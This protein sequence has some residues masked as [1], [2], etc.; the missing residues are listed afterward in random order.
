[1]QWKGS[2]ALISLWVVI[3]VLLQVGLLHRKK[4]IQHVI[5]V[6]DRR[7]DHRKKSVQ[8]TNPT[9]ANVGK[10]AVGDSPGC[11][12]CQPKRSRMGSGRW[13]TACKGLVRSALQGAVWFPPVP[14]DQIVGLDPCLGNFWT[15]LGAFSQASALKAGLEK[16]QTSNTR[17]ALG[18]CGWL[19]A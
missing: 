17:S 10:C 18:I 12:C 4:D 3:A 16:S 2:P 19:P 13:E 8:G 6:Q 14:A 1:M 15:L 11:H 9:Q 7:P 5:V